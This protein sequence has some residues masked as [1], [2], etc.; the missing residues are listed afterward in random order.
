[1]E[2]LNRVVSNQ[3]NKENRTAFGLNKQQKPM[4]KHP[5]A[6]VLN[7]EKPIE[8]KHIKQSMWQ[9]PSGASKRAS[10]QC[11]EQFKWQ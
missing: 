4:K 8:F 9:E 1:M 11:K 5:Q 2:I 3:S 7:C 6:Q 10:V